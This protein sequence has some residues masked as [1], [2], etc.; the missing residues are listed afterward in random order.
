MPLGGD[1]GFVG[2]STRLLGIPKPLGI[3]V[4]N[5]GWF[6]SQPENNLFL[7]II[8]HYIDWAFVYYIYQYLGIVFDYPNP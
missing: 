1:S 8:I 3:P 4:G 7:L 2:G 6:R 5:D